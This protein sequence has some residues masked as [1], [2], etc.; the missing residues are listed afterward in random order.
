MK[1]DATKKLE[2][3]KIT[4]QDLDDRQ[5]TAA[6]GGSVFTLAVGPCATTATTTDTE[7]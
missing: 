6:K 3:N 1:K 7:G 5:M 2:L 4:I